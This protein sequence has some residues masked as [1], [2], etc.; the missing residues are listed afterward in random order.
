[1]FTGLT[2]REQRSLIL[3]VGLIAV[4]VGIRHIRHRPRTDVELLSSK[5][6]VETREQDSGKDVRPPALVPENPPP[7]VN[8]NTASL[9]ELCRLRGVGPAKAQKIIEYRTAHGGFRS[10]E[11]LGNVWGIGRVT[12]EGLRG[13]VTV[14]KMGGENRNEAANTSITSPPDGAIT[15]EVDPEPVASASSPGKDKV[16]INRADREELM[17]LEQ[18]GEVKAARIIEYRRKYGRFRSKRDI[19]KVKGIGEKTFLLN[20]GKITVK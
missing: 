12:L 8:V 4:G 18:I 11:E 16:N 3:L 20:Q 15:H 1:M 14:G 5:T 17:T 9:E 2:W 13:G 19:M 7:L 10:I 6:P